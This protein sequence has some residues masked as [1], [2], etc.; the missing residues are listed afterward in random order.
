MPGAW[1]ASGKLWRETAEKVYTI[2]SARPSAR[3]ILVT[4]FLATTISQFVIATHSTQSSPEVIH[5]YRTL[6][7]FWKRGQLFVEVLPPLS[8]PVQLIPVE[9]QL[10]I[11]SVCPAIPTFA[12]L[13]LL[14]RLCMFANNA[15]TSLLFLGSNSVPAATLAETIISVIIVGSF[16]RYHSIPPE[17]VA[18]TGLSTSK[19]IGNMLLLLLACICLPRRQHNATVTSLVLCVGA[20]EVILALSW[21]LGSSPSDVL[22]AHAA[23]YIPRLYGLVRDLEDLSTPVSRLAAKAAVI[24]ASPILAF[25][26]VTIMITGL[27][28]PWSETASGG[29]YNLHYLPM[30]TRRELRPDISQ[31]A[32]RD[33]TMLPAAGYNSST[34]W[35]DLR[36]GEPI[37]I[38]LPLAGFLWSDNFVWDDQS[39]VFNIDSEVAPL[40]EAMLASGRYPEQNH[41]VV[42]QDRINTL[43]TSSLLFTA[44][45]VNL[46]N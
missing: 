24:H 25:P 40:A 6:F 45:L 26:L 9:L 44:R 20:A 41:R 14:G 36:P 18:C 10:A 30:N 28:Y 19:C 7:E 37:S 1:H 46:T 2:M 43:S 3:S 39:Q 33:T 31:T 21:L 22:L 32:R 12:S 38:Y 27:V 35:H 11:Q 29:N 17:T 34:R 16:A 8:F 15:Q 5:V 13:Y 42:F 4:V 23:L